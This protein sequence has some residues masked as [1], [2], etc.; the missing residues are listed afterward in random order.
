MDRTLVDLAL[1]FLL[2]DPNVHRV[3]REE[4][5]VEDE[6]DE[7]EG[8]AAALHAEAAVREATEAPVVL[9]TRT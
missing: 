9:A 7:G 5:H 4:D 6:Q 2:V 3:R 1:Q 8:Q